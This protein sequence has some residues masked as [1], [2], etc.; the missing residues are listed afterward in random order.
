MDE[1]GRVGHRTEDSSLH[2]DHFQGRRMVAW[3]GGGG[4]IGEDEA[5]VTTI[6][7]FSHGGMHANVCGDPAEDYVSDASSLEKHVKVG[8]LE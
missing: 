5:F 2:L 4:A 3:I 8:P 1:S 7:C 6:I